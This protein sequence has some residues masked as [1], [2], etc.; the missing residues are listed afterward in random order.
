[1]RIHFE[2]QVVSVVSA[3]FGDHCESLAEHSVLSMHK[4]QWALMLNL[5]VHFV[6][7]GFGS[8]KM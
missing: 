2:D 5:L 6:A 4:M 7:T 1:M 3:I 8:F